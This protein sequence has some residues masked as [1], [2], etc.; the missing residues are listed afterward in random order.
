M[1]SVKGQ[2]GGISAEAAFED[3]A[4]RTA[5]AIEA[6]AEHRQI[7]QSASDMSVIAEPTADAA[8]TRSDE[9]RATNEQLA[10]FD[11]LLVRLERVG[12]GV[13][14]AALLSAGRR[15]DTR[16]A[17]VV[18][19][20]FSRQATI[21]VASTTAS[22]TVQETGRRLDSYVFRMQAI[23]EVEEA[24]W[25]G[26]PPPMRQAWNQLKDLA[27]EA[28]FRPTKVTVVAAVEFDK[29]ARGWAREYASMVTSCLVAGE[30][31]VM[32]TLAPPPN[33]AG[34]DGD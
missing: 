32:D 28:E 13:R 5:A 2:A 16:E 4:V 9:P 3:R 7:L 20:Q 1:K 30:H 10:L 11:R 24:L 6:V 18:M 21:A 31:L 25:P 22:D 26:S 33:R 14:T 29:A 15:E 8:V 27:R 23:A 12:P 19:E 17:L 34:A